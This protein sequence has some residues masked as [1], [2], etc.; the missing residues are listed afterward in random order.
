MQLTEELE[1]LECPAEVVA[2][3]QASTP[4]DQLQ[5][6]KALHVFLISVA[7]VGEPPNNARDFYNWLMDETSHIKVNSQAPKSDDNVFSSLQYTV[8]GL[9]NQ[10]AHPNHYN[11]I[12][13]NVDKRLEELGARRMLPLGLGDDG[14]CLEDD[15]DTWKDQLLKLIM[16]N[17]NGGDESN[18]IEREVHEDDELTDFASVVVEESKDD[19]QPSQG[20]TAMSEPSRRTSEKYPLLYL[21]PNIS[22]ISCQEDLFRLQS[23]SKPFYQEGTSRLPVKANRLLSANAGE[24][25]LR[26]LQISLRGDEKHFYEAGD[27]LIVYPCNASCIVEAYLNMLDVNPNTLIEEPDSSASTRQR[28]YPHPVGITLHETLT[29]CVDL[30]A[31]PSPA[32]SRML[33]GRQEIEYRE[34]VVEPRRTALDLI[35]ESGHLPSVEELLYNLPPMKPRYYSIASSALVHPTDVIITYRPIKYV[36]SRGYLRE[37]VCTSYM[38]NLG[39]GETSSSHI[40][41]GIRSNPTF[42]LP[43]D[44]ETPILMIAGG[45]GIAPIR[46]FLE[47][48]IA[49][50][51]SS[52]FGKGHLYLGFRSPSDEVYRPMIQHAQDCGAITDVKVTYST[53]CT[54][55]ALVS[56]TVRENGAEVFAL[57]Q[58]GGYA[59]MCGGARAFGAAVEREI[60]A[61]FQ[62]HGKMSLEE[63]S[64]HLRKLISEGR[65][66]EDLAD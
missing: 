23:S 40:A 41:A 4:A 1:E 13:K 18:E 32:F 14:E 57:L 9:G 12:G 25:G 36:T 60:L 62:E 21:R 64:D 39:V 11:V 65:L 30:G 59:Y 38:T 20:S 63:A 35:H 31:A 52:N 46:A 51:G 48:R 66:C 24:S 8:F 55:P 29:H 27:H 53:G 33:L 49:L 6:G 34:D 28:A 15:F 2:L 3:N 45:C 7:G 37:G 5:P 17:R 44:R 50:S 43:N 19:P 47:E 61:V 22:P 16:K 56:T 54:S 26:E 10:K 58:D 42:R